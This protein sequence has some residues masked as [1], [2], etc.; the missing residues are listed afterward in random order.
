MSIGLPDIE[1]YKDPNYVESVKESGEEDNYT[2]SDIF[3]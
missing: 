1:K 3:N 2:Y